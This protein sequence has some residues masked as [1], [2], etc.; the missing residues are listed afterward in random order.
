VHGAISGNMELSFVS[1]VAKKAIWSKS[2][3]KI[4]LLFAPVLVSM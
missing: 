1:L 4:S 2:V 3:I